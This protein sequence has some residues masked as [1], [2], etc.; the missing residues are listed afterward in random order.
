M[1]D[2]VIVQYKQSELE[3]NNYK[4][5]LIKLSEFLGL[6]AAIIAFI[7]VIS[8]LLIKYISFGRCLYFDFDLNYYDFSLSN[9]SLIIFILCIISSIIASIL[10]VFISSIWIK[11]SAIIDKKNHKKLCKCIFIIIIVV[12]SVFFIYALSY[13]CFPNKELVYLF[14]A[15]T[16]MFSI[17]IYS[18]VYNIKQNIDKN[19]NIKLTL[20]ISFIIS[21]FLTVIMMKYNYDEGKEQLVFP[22]I[23]EEI[24][25]E[26][27]YYVVISEGKMYSAYW[28]NIDYTTDTLTIKKNYHKYFDIIETTAIPVYFKE[29]EY[30]ST[31]YTPLGLKYYLNNN[32]DNGL[33]NNNGGGV[34]RQL[35]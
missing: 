6:F 9:T 19:K 14:T 25:N 28:C 26:I 33:I 18:I 12:L 13:M 31:V 5:S 27:Y 2:E 32:I 10:S 4:N 21:M 16:T 34:K 22:I 7:S 15:T 1:D 17:T 23:V 24:D 30:D 35:D 20:I 8:T 3:Q 29:I 11:F